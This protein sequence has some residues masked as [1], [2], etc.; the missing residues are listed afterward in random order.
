MVL[1]RALPPKPNIS[2]E[3]RE[4]L[5][6]LRR[7]TDIMGLPA[8]KGNATVGMGK[9]EYHSKI[10]EILA[11]KAYVRLSRDL[12]DAIMRKTNTLIKKT[13]F[14]AEIAKNLRPQAPAPQRLYGLPKIHKIGAPLRPI[15]SAIGS[16]TY[17]LAKHLTSVLSPHVG[18]CEHHLRNSADFVK[19]PEGIHLA[20]GDILVSLDVVSL[21]TRVSLTDTLR[22]LDAKF[23]AAT[24][25]LFRHV[26]TSTYF[27][28]DGQY[29]E[30]ADGVAMGSPLSPAIANFFMEDFEEKALKSSPLRPKYFFRYVDDNLC[31]LATWEGCT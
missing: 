22:L 2:K 27:L 6:A 21:F 7:N 11:D 16:P 18:C 14:P 24:V 19:I 5:Q 28:Y 10:R 3:E 15:V 13:E 31:D 12:T 1:K 17:K 9:E 8:D 20:E 30:Q 26:L 4:A 29:F 25:M 23:D